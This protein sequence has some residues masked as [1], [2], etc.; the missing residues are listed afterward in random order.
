[1]GDV[2]EIWKTFQE[3]QTITCNCDIKT[4]CGSN[5]LNRA[6]YYECN[7]NNCALGERNC[8][9]RPFYELQQRLKLDTPFSRG[10]ELI[11]VSTQMFNLSCGDSLTGVQTKDRGY[12]L[13]ANRSFAPNQIVVEYSGEI[14]TPE[15]CER[16]IKYEYAKNSV[17]V[18]SIYNNTIRIFTDPGYAH[19]K[20]LLFDDIPQDDNNRC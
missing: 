13:R 19:D 17:W 4:G 7:K 6:V 2:G 10:V 15:E 20:V 3:D 11:Q 9:N 5:C 1:M 14:I 12:G 8:G 16:R 18:P